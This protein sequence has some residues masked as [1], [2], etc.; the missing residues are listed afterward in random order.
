[1]FSFLLQ[2]LLQFCPMMDLQKYFPFRCKP[3]EDF[4]ADC[5]LLSKHLSEIRTTSDKHL[6][7]IFFNPVSD[8]VPT[9]CY[10]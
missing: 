10:V 5:Q 3:S 6:V 9:L 8:A 1:M 2:Y 4:L 7:Q